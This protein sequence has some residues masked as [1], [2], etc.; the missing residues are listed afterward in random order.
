[1]YIMQ[2]NERFIFNG[3]CVVY[4]RFIE[5]NTKSGLPMELMSNK[6]REMIAGVNKWF[7]EHI[8][9]EKEASQ[10]VDAQGA[11]LPEQTKHAVETQATKKDEC[12]IC[13][14]PGDKP[15]NTAIV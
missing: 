13:L 12:V 2:P 11:E 8:C 1:M 10:K 3:P 7:R 4:N 9:K 14:L 5:L 6:C 15:S